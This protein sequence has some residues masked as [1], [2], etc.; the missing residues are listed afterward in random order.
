MLRFFYGPVLW[1]TSIG[2]MCILLAQAA[3]ERFAAVQ[4]ADVPEPSYAHLLSGGPLEQV[5]TARGIVPMQHGDVTTTS[6]TKE[7]GSAGG[8]T[9]CGAGAPCLQAPLYP[10]KWSDS[11]SRGCDEAARKVRLRLLSLY[12][13]RPS[14]RSAGCPSG[15]PSQKAKKACCFS[16]QPLGQNCLSSSHWKQ[17]PMMSQCCDFML[18][19]WGVICS[20]YSPEPSAGSGRCRVGKS[21]PNRGRFSSESILP[22]PDPPAQVNVDLCQ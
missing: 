20:R 18:Y 12:C 14:Q 11:E 16:W 22:G 19:A 2:R 3:S 17:H 4:A 7:A 6:A 8:D 1:R 13:P 10:L 21:G 5:S 15:F 9:Q